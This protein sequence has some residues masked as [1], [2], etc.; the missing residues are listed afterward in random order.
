V[1]IKVADEVEVD[2]S[3]HAWKVSYADATGGAREI[4]VDGVRV[5]FI[6]L[7]ELI[8]SKE[9][10]REQDRLDRLR[11]LELKRLAEPPA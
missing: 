8:A 4:V 10:Y 7:D 9:T 3:T 6:G 11:L 1:V 5:P 2:V